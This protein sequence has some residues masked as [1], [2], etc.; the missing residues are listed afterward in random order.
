MVPS[1]AGVAV[2]SAELRLESVPPFALR[3]ASALVTGVRS[4]TDRAPVRG[5]RTEV[6]PYVCLRQSSIL[7]R[8]PSI[9]NPQSSILNHLHSSGYVGVLGASQYSGD[10][11][12]ASSLT[13]PAP[14]ANPAMCA[15]KA[16]PPASAPCAAASDPTPLSSCIRNQKPRKTTAGI[17][18]MFT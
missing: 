12:G 9:V 16:M 3:L 4:A 2:A 7:N 17:S 13:S 15:Q 5:G 1:G 8:Q 6:R 11:G 18:T 10:C 14:T